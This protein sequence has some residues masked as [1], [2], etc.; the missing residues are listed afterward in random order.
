MEDAAGPAGGGVGGVPEV[1]ARH[2]VVGGQVAK[3]K[4]IRNAHVGMLYLEHNNLWLGP[5]TGPRLVTYVPLDQESRER[6]Q[7]LERLTAP[8]GAGLLG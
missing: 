2:E 8:A 4:Y 3:S 5:R 7:E 1:W 6:L